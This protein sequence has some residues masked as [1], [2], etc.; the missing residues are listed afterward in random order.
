LCFEKV[1]IL[2]VDADA[3]VLFSS[4]S[5]G[6]R[7]SISSVHRLTYD[8][9]QRGRGQEDNQLVV[10]NDERQ[11]AGPQY[12]WIAFNSKIAQSLNWTLSKTNLFEWL[13]G[14]GQVMVRSGYWKDGWVSLEPPRFEGLG[15]G[16]YVLASNRAVETIWSAFP[17]A[18]SHLW[19]SRHAHGDNPYEESW[20]L[21]SNDRPS[22]FST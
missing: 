21:R 17:N 4:Y 19:V 18:E 2:G 14:D 8:A 10:Y 1:I 11:L 13:D 5:V 6:Q 12:R 22:L 3:L 16:W 15:G 20:H 9:Y 7:E